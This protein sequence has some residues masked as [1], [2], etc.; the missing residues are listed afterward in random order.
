MCGISGF[1]GPK[2]FFPKEKKVKALLTSM[3]RRGPDGLGTFVQKSKKMSMIFLHTRLAIIDLQK[4]SN[5]PFEDERGILS[6]NGEIYNY[7][8]LREICLQRGLKF[9]TQSDTEVLLKMLNL[10]GEKALKLLDG[11]WSFSYYDKI[12][13]RVILSRDRF[14]EKPLYYIKNKDY[15]IFGSNISYLNFLSHKKLILDKQR[16]SDFL[17]LGFKSLGL[18]HTTLFKNVRTLRPGSMMIINFN[19]K[20]KTNIRKYWTAKFK[21]T[22]KHS[23]M[24]AV[25]I[26]R[27]KILNVFST[28]FRSDV[29]LASLL[30]GGMDSSSILSVAK[31]TNI[32]LKCYS[33][34]SNLKEYNEESAI[35]TNIKFSQFAH[36]F[37]NIPKKNNFNTLKKIVKYQSYPLSTPQAFATALICKKIKS[38]G[39]KVVLSGTGGDEFFAG[40]YHHYLAYLYSIQKNE[41]FIEVHNIWKKKV[42]KYI[43]S[44]EMKNFQSFK[45]NVENRLSTASTNQ[46]ED[47]ELKKYVN[48]KINLQQTK[49]YSN[50]FYFNVMLQDIRQNSLIHQLDM[51]DSIPM[52]Y[53]I[54]GRS[55]FLSS[56]IFDFINTLPKEY[57]FNKGRSKSLLRDAMQDYI[58]KSICG[59]LKKIG[60]YISFNEIFSKKEKSNIY[61]MITNSNFLKKILNMKEIIK[62]FKKKNVKH[63][64][65]KFLFSAVNLAILGNMYD[66]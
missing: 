30:S 47:Q 37:V 42:S 35:K 44:K 46:H 55:P 22:F 24:E 1:I 45:K 21:L 39:Y 58:P 17:L 15:L 13:K 50:D 41:N 31:R 11:M 32:N 62:L 54:E 12:K 29:P 20:L 6:F 56:D 65:A 33:V 26:L 14:G 23:Y 5:Q 53:S 64:E 40:Y 36:D 18:N 7:I 25:G 8:E 34:K 60:F 51:L 4:E 48:R 10:Y 59:N 3:K 19:K 27:E 2:N 57:F 49:K 61:K 66:N 38:Q 9:K 63:S 28:R 52:F 43:R 16:A